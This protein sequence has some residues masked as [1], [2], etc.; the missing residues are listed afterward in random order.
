MLDARIPAALGASLILHGAA[1]ALVDRLPRGGS[2]SAPEWGAWDAGGLQARLRPLAQAVAKP[3]ARSAAPLAGAQRQPA[4][5]GAVPAAHGIATPPQYLVAE[6]LD[7][8]PQIRTAVQPVFPELA[9]P[10]GRVVVRL[11]IN[12]AG[13]VDDVKALRAE[14]SGI[15][16]AAAIE[17][18]KA[19]RFTPGRKD[20][21]AVKSA[22]DVELLFGEAPPVHAQARLDDQPL[23]QPPRRPRGMRNPSMQEKP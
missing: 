12:E 1:L 10:S 9:P 11:Y 8:R 21:V 20:G 23:W 17:A 18:F 19:A 2:A 5:R 7:E 15:F 6:E 3:A 14:P 13:L 16:E 22:L 4:A